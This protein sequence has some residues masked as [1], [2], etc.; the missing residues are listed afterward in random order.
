VIDAG[1]VIFETLAASLDPYPRKPNAEFV[2]KIEKGTDPAA[3]GP[4][5]GLSSLKD[6]Q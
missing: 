4:F 2:W 1:R 3:A 6:K 5:A